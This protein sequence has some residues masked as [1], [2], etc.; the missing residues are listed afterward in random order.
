MFTSEP[1]LAQRIERMIS[2]TPVIDPYSHLRGDAPA[3]P[4]LAALFFNDSMAVEL[5]AV[6]MPDDIVVGVPRDE[7]VRRMLPFLRRMRNTT[8]AWCFYRILRDLYDFQDPHLTES[9][10]RD[11]LDKVERTGHEPSWTQSV[12]KER[13]NLQAVVTGWSGGPSQGDDGLQLRLDLHPLFAPGMVAS[14][15]GSMPLRLSGQEF[16]AG[17]MMVVGQLAATAEGLRSQLCDRLDRT[18][19]GSGRFASTYWPIERRFRAPVVSDAGV[20]VLLSRVRLG[21]TVA[22]DDITTLVDFVGW[23]V[24]AWH[25]EHRKTLQVA[26]GSE[27]PS[28]VLAVS[29]PLSCPRYD[30]SW[31]RDLSE[32][33]RQF[34]NA[35]FDLLIGSEPLAHDATSLARQLPNVSVSGYWSHTFTLPAIERI[36]AQ[37][38]QQAPM[39]KV[40]GFLSDATQVEWVYGKFQLVRKATA[41]ALAHL[42]EAGI[43]EEEEIPPIL[44]QIFYDTPRELYG[45]G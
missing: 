27:A 5:H 29:S 41:S 17:G 2:A 7:V 25:H 40:G 37:R 39:T 23:N 3:A 21:E 45:L 6:G 9:N 36:L 10:Y 33:F 35:R 43:Y 34:S 14:I 20:D 1:S 12:L 42:V 18:L 26:V 38:V 31:V 22:E 28:A 32:T 11:L 24:L 19:Y 8:T 16:A 13:C 15:A 4:D 44:R 30:P